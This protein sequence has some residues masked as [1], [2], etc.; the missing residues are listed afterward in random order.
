MQAINEAI[1]EEMERDP[2]LI[3]MGE[4]VAVRG[5]PFGVTKGLADLFGQGR[6]IDTPISESGFT[7]AAVAAAIAGVPAISEIGYIDFTTVAMD[8]IVNVAAKAHYMSGGRQQVPVVIRTQEGGGVGGGATHSQC[9]EAWFTHVPGMKVVLPSTPYDYKGLLKTAV[10][11]PNPVVFI[12]HKM[13]YRTKGQVPTGEY[14]I[15]L[16]LADVKRAGKD[17]TVVAIGAMV[18]KALA[19]A[20]KLAAEGVDIE[21]IDPRTLVPLDVETIAG[22]VRRTGRLVVFQEAYVGSSFGGEIARVVGEVA[23]DYLE[24]PIKVVGARSPIPFSPALE[25]LAIPGEQ[26]LIAAVRKALS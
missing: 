22:S 9:L 24:A 7:T 2:R 26:D 4:D 23:F 14:A 20:Q 1:K 11:E 6:V 3:I 25:Q 15:P 5:G 18:P 16:G 8:P 10:R 12:E 13:L 21:V 17:I 19:A